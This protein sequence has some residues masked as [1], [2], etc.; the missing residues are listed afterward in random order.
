MIHAILRAG[1]AAALLLVLPAA[2]LDAQR[3]AT[4]ARAEASYG[5]LAY[6]QAITHA[7][8]ALGERLPGPDQARAWELMGFAY[9][10]LD[11]ARQSTEAFKQLLFLE[12]DRELDPARIS[13]KIT[14]L[15]AL[16]LGQILVVRHV[17]ADTT[18][19]IAGRGALSIRFTVTRGARV[20]TRIV[21]PGGEALVD[22]SLTDGTLRL[23]W[24]GLLRDGTPAPGGDYRLIVE[25]VAG[26]DAY[27]ASVPLRITAGAV[28]TLAHLASLPGY[29][30]LPET[31][32]PPRSWRPLGIALIATAA[33]SGTIMALESADLAAIGRREL[34][35]IGVG[36]SIVGLVATLR[37]PA[38]VPAPANIRYNALVR[39]QLARRNAELAEESARRR[40]Q[41]QLTVVPV[42]ESAAKENEP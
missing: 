6:A 28:D 32:I 18:T 29:D 1:L 9:A 8:R 7:R 4:L 26:R 36:T 13:P 27:A 38:P 11:S 21:G 42:A 10:A 3:S 16:A 34:V 41:V 35:T 2:S 22:S 5:E 12:P 23:S 37:R 19:F 15:F 14:S 17:S 25:A 24:D 30:L 40:R 39:E 20:R 33:T 31:G